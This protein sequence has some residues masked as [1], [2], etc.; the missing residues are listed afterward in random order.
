MFP[1]CLHIFHTLNFLHFLTLYFSGNIKWWQLKLRL[2]YLKAWDILCIKS[3]F[4]ISKSRRLILNGKILNE[5][6]LISIKLSP[7][8]FIIRVFFKSNTLHPEKRWINANA[9]RLISLFFSLSLPH[10]QHTYPNIHRLKTISQDKW[11]SWTVSYNFK[12]IL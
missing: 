2:C 11:N 3:E 12:D 10:T 5:Q 8:N 1:K 7:C 4:Q 9:Q 6:R